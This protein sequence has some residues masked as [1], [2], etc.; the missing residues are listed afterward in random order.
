[1]IAAHEAAFTKA[2]D[3]EDGN[4][5]VKFHK[6]TLASHQQMADYHVG[7]I[8]ECQKA[9]AASDLAKSNAPVP[10]RVLAFPRDFRVTAIPRAG[11]PDMQKTEVPLEF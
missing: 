1:M 10:D 4:H 5:H 7:A 3:M 8:K 11:A 6:S 2:K 9:A